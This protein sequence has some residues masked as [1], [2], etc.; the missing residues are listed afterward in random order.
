VVMAAQVGLLRVSNSASW[1]R[2]Q[3]V[4]V[5]TAGPT[6]SKRPIESLEATA[7]KQLPLEQTRRR[8]APSAHLS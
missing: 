5:A 6:L 3:A 8:V 7:K 4:A 2:V 1:R